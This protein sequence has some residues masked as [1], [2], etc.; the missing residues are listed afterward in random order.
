MIE[1]KTKNLV[2]LNT[3][4]SNLIP[5]DRRVPKPMSQHAKPKKRQSDRPGKKH[6]TEI[7]RDVRKSVTN[8]SNHKV[9]ERGGL[10]NEWRSLT[11]WGEISFSDELIWTLDDCCWVLGYE[12]FL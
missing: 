11:F 4:P 7:R 2:Q 8:A 3:Y 9:L 12:V 6:P 5:R 1:K 10:L